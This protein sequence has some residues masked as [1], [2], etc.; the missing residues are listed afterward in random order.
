MSYRDRAI[1]VIVAWAQVLNRF[2]VGIKPLLLAC[3]VVSAWAIVGSGDFELNNYFTA[4][5]S[6]VV[7]GP[8]TPNEE[9]V[10]RGKENVRL[11]FLRI[12][13]YGNTVQRNNPISVEI[14]SGHSS[15]ILDLGI[16]GNSI[17]QLI[18]MHPNAVG[19]NV[20]SIG[21]FKGMLSGLHQLT[22]QARLPSSGTSGTGDNKRANNINNESLFVGGIIVATGGFIL[23]CKTWWNLSFNCSANTN[24]AIYAALVIISAILF[25]MGSGMVLS[26]CRL[27]P[28]V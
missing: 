1:S 27:L 14:S 20:G 17:F 18:N 6:V 13:L 2:I 28:L 7:A 11:G 16:E 21:G 23:F 26:A 9:D 12:A 22:S 4:H 25:W 24:A 10:L 3:C 15:K 19:S 8:H 5:N